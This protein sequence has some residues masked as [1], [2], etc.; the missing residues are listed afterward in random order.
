MLSIVIPIYNRRN[1]LRLCLAALDKQS[2]KD[3]EV[4]IADDGSDDEPFMVLKE[5]IQAL[6]CRYVWHERRGVQIAATRNEGVRIAQGNP[7]LF[8]DSDVL[9]N[10]TAIGHYMNIYNA[11][12]DVVVAGRYDWLPPMQAAVYS[13]HYNW[14]RLIRGELPPMPIEGEPEGIQGPDPRLENPNLFNS[15]V[16]QQ[17]PYCLS[18]FSGNLLVPRH[19]FDSVGGWDGNMI[20]HG[21]EDAEFGM[22]LQEAGIPVIF[23]DEVVGYHFYHE[24]DQARNISELRVNCS[25]MAAQ[26]NFASLGVRFGSKGESALVYTEGVGHV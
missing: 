10:P 8:L 5:Y 13:V 3:F 16:I 19:I 4:V 1:G 9:L 6:S 11:N 23:A 12:P 14:D 18:M 26:H 24:R 7:F 17:D 25:Y 2:V 22:R 21:G 15:G 20:G